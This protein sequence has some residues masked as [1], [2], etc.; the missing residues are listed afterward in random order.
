MQVLRD[1][2]LIPVVAVS[3]VAERIMTVAAASAGPVSMIVGSDP[4]LANDR[5]RARGRAAP[6]RWGGPA[7]ASAVDRSPAVQL[8]VDGQSR[9]AV[10]E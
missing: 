3:Q 10:L 5:M 8:V 7:R 2:W 9:R 1:S 6:K 4:T